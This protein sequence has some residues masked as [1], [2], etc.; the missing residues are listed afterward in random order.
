MAKIWMPNDRKVPVNA[1][2]ESF[3]F[4]IY[5]LLDTYFREINEINQNIGYFQNKQAQYKS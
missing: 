3:V 1:L 5:Q 4:D 2:M